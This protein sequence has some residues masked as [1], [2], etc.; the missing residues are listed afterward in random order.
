MRLRKLELPSRMGSAREFVATLALVSLV[1]LPP[2]LIARGSPY[3]NLGAMWVS[4]PAFSLIQSNYT[5]PQSTTSPVSVAYSSAQIAGDT[6]VIVIGWNDA[7]STISSVADTSGNSYAVAAPVVR[8]STDGISQAIY[9]AKS[10]AA[11]AAGANSVTVTFSAAVPYPDVRI[12][13]YKGLHP[14]SPL[15]NGTG[16]S[17]TGATTASAGTITVNSAYEVLIGGATVSSSVF[18]TATGMMG[19]I[20]TSPNGDSVQEQVVAATG[21]YGFTEPMFSGG[22]AMNVAAFRLDR[23]DTSPPISLVQ[24]N[25]S[26]SGS[27]KT[28]TRTAVFSSAQT[29]GNM[30]IVVASWSSSSGTVSV[31]DT[32]NGSYSSAVGAIHTTSGGSMAIFYKSGIASAAAGSNTVTATLSAAATDFDVAILEYHGVTTL[33]TTGS[34]AISGATISNTVTSTTNPSLL[35]TGMIGI[36]TNPQTGMLTN[37]TTRVWTSDQLYVGDLLTTTPAAYTLNG[38]FEFTN[39]ETQVSAVFH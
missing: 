25:S 26:A 9:Y 5:T 11:A 18:S 10:I 8:D 13:E 24:D 3:Y 31:S 2:G 29:S 1:L 6:N 12:L 30:N 33:D 16:S 19:Q 17:G 22:Y 14:T 34:A 36:N 38:V 27:T 28:T 37:T 15:D 20:I 21:S 7:T 39:N 32:T 35:I 23:A 4:R